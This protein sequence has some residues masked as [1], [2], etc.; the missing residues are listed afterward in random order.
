MKRSVSLL[1]FLALFYTLI[2]LSV[3]AD[4]V[5]Q[6]LESVIIENFDDPNARQ[7]NVQASKFVADGLPLVTYAE[8]YPEALFGRNNQGLDLKVLGVKAAYD[9][10]GYN[11]LEI[12]P[13]EEDSSGVLVPDP[14]T[15]P[16]R[17][18]QFDLWV[19][20][21]NYDFYIEVHLRDYVG[22]MHVLQL[23]E[24]QYVGWR[25][26]KTVIPPYV[27]QAGGYISEGGFLKTLELVK[28]VIW[29]KPTENVNGFNVY[30]DQLKIL[31][32]TFVSRFDGD[33]LADPEKVNDI[34]ASAGGN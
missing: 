22:R 10:K 6:N 20:G 19:W 1:V 23:G 30:L 29:T 2:A 8:S 25:N 12:Y 31:T 21:S 11:Y 3:S 4:E 17:V 13:V 24:L 5:T 16:G 7:W 28:L 33:D 15:L 26:L 9:R 27:P 18:M 32:D 34:W 14:I